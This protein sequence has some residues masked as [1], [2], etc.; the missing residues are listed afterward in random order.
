MAGMVGK[1]MTI[2]L[3]LAGVM[4]LMMEPV[5]VCLTEERALKEIEELKKKKV[6]DFK[7]IEIEVKE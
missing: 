1:K 7:I 4:P 2:F 3:V 5:A 6:L